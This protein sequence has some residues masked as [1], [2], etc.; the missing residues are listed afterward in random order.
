MIEIS[1]RPAG[2]IEGAAHIERIRISKSP[3]GIYIE[4]AC[5]KT[6]VLQQAL[7]TYFCTQLPV[8]RQFR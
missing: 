3:D 5:C 6:K 1:S 2:H 8:A 4:R 7:N